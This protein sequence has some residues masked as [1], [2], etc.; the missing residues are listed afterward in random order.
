MIRVKSKSAT[1]RIGL[2]PEYVDFNQPIEVMFNGKRITPTNGIVLPDVRVQI[3][4]ARTRRDR[5]HPFWAI[6]AT[7]K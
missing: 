2:S 7:K 1:A 3:E 4:D 5:Q 6:L